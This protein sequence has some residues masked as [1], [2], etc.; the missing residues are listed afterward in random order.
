MIANPQTVLALLPAA[1]RHRLEELIGAVS[2]A[3]DP[4]LLSVIVYGSAVRGGFTLHSDVDLLL[5]VDDDDPLL[6]RRL[7]DPL[8]TGRAAARID[9]RI[10]RVAE[11]PRAADVFPVLYDDVRACHA[12]LFGS[13]PFKDL[14]IHDE[15]RRLRVEQELRDV[16]IRLRRLLTDTAFDDVRLGL[17]V[18]HKLKQIRAPLWSLLKLH[19]VQTADDLITVLDVIGKRL[20]VDTIALTQKASSSLPAATALCVLLDAAIHDVDTLRT[21]PVEPAR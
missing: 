10:L 12:V 4:H 3:L 17:G 2:T 11:I 15:H 1:V 18:D 7:H 8:A 19:G 14:V 6:L 16:R 21:A 9:C 5:I 20:K 13:D